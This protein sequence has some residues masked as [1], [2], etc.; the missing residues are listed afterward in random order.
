[1]ATVKLQTGNLP[2]RALP[3]NQDADK[4][5]G[6]F[7]HFTSDVLS[8]VTSG[9]R[10]VDG[11]ENELI[12]KIA[13]AAIT[14]RMAAMFNPDVVGIEPKRL[15]IAAIAALA[16]DGQPV[17]KNLRDTAEGMTAEEADAWLVETQLAG[18]KFLNRIERRWRLGV[19]VAGQAY[20]IRAVVVQCMQSKTQQAGLVAFIDATRAIVADV[21]NEMVTAKA[22]AKAAP[23]ALKAAKKYLEDKVM[24]FPSAD[25][26]ALIASLN[27]MHAAA[28]NIETAAAARGAAD[29]DEEEEEEA[30]AA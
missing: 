8:L 18:F 27:A 28:V 22:K 4:A 23:D 9:F 25:I 29:E 14:Q 24:G 3:H 12:A 7:A 15:K 11:A 26:A 13:F 20:K 19:K 6:E 2:R 1:M 17:F 16:M 10:Y 21:V 5:S 30:I